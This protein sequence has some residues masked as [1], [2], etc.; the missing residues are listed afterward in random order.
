MKYVIS[1]DSLEPWKIHEGVTAKIVA[2]GQ[3]MTAMM[4]IWEAGSIF[5]AHT[6]PNEQI[7]ICI[8]GEIIFTIEGQDYLVKTG[9]VYNIPSN[10]PHGER[11]EGQVE[12]VCVECFSPIREDL[13]KR[14][15][16]EMPMVE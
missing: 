16:F 4:S 12:A 1:P 3:K 10:V 13:V 7:G 14:R 9:D 6:H 15:R 2:E 5:G 11:N 8:K